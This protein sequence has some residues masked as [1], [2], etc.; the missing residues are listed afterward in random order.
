[1]KS[2]RINFPNG[3]IFE[4]ESTVIAT[5]RTNHYSKKE[6]ISKDSV[7]WNA[8]FEYSMQSDIL[9][10]WIQNDVD[11]FEIEDHA[12][13]IEPEKISY[14]TMFDNAKFKIK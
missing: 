14:D 7:E 11:W 3:H 4:V 13:F 9:L 10:D 1:M 6:G 5:L 8:E 12:I 2:I